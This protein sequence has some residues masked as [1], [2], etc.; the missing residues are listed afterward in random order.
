MSTTQQKIDFLT[1]KNTEIDA[2]IAQKGQQKLDLDAAI[3]QQ[4]ANITYFNGQ[5]DICDT[6]IAS[7]NAD[8]AINNE[9]IVVLEQL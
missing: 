1:A 3:A 5:K 6:D 2:L 7:Y 8:K 9:I 4:E